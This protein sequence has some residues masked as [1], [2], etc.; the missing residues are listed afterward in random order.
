AEASKIVTKVLDL[1]LGEV[2]GDAWYK[3]YVRA[4][5][6]KAAIPTTIASFDHNVTRGEMAEMI[7]RIVNNVS[8]KT[9]LSYLGL[10]NRV[11]AEEGN[12][13]KFTSCDDVKDYLDLVEESYYYYDLVDDGTFAESSSEA[14]GSDDYSTTNVQVGGVDEADIVKNTGDYIF[15]V[16]K[17]VVEIIGATP[18]DEVGKINRIEFDDSGFTPEEIYVDSRR[19]RLMVIG[20]NYGDVFILDD[21]DEDVVAQIMPR[22]SSATV[23]F[24]LYDISNIK[25]IELMRR[26]SFEGYYSS[27]RKVGEMVYL[28]INK[29][30]YSGYNELDEPIPYFGDTGKDATAALSRCED[31]W[32]VPGSQSSQFTIVAGIDIEDDNSRIRREV[33]LGGSDNV[34]A[35]TEN[36]YLVSENYGGDWGIWDSTDDSD[37]EQQTFI[38][39]FSLADDIEYLGK[40][41]VEGSV[42][43]QF[44]MDEYD[45]HFRV[46]TT[47]GNVWDGSSRSGVYVFDKDMRLVGSVE[48]IAPGEK[49]YSARFSGDK[50]YLVTFKKVDPFFVLDMSDH[51]EPKILGKLKIPGYSDYLHIYSD[52]YVIGFGKDTVEPTEDEKGGRNLDFAW[53]QGL[54]V[55]MFDVTDVENPIE[56]HKLVIG[57]RGTDSELL[58]NHKALLFEKGRNLLAFPVLLAELEAEVK[59]DLTA[60]GDEYGDYTFQGAYIYKI[61]PEEGFE[62]IG[63]PTHYEAEEVEKRSGLYWSGDRDIRRILRIGDYIYTLSQRRLEVNDLDDMELEYDV[64]E[65]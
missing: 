45:E 36:L 64:V 19:D 7:Y 40:G 10:K 60:N 24:Y 50:A 29:Y 8:V 59:D 26:V 5:E 47:V 2:S 34:Y 25:K 22:P 31:I 42:L 48:D 53:Y 62:L 56:L 51:Q 6:L 43:N 14:T 21:Q 63:T 61:T 49:I 9:S 55:A 44:S 54:K 23:D 4:L 41:Q 35:S 3:V 27:S 13:L 28:V 39:K 16:N 30:G 57:D 20:K 46:A 37:F 17:G 58:S 38:H 1:S 11:L 15:Y 32:Y 65:F 33:I 12:L 52:D 18:V